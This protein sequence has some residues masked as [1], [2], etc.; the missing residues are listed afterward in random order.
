MEEARKRPLDGPYYREHSAKFENIT[1]PVL[2]AANWGGTGMHPRGNYEGYL[3]A[4]ST[5][6]W[7]SVHGDTHFGPFYRASGVNMQKQFLDHFLKGEDNGWDKQPQVLIDIRRPGE[8]FTT[9]AEHEWPLARTEWTKFY[10]DPTDMS[11]RKAPT[12]VASVTYDPMG[13]GLF[14]FL[15][16]SEK[17]VEITGPI[18]ARLWV[19]SETADADLFLVLRLYDPD[20]KEILFVGSNDPR[21]PITFGW[22]RA[23]HRKLDPQK[24]LPH[25]PYH[26]H[27]EVW[28][29]TPGEPVELL[30][31]L[32][33]TCIVIPPGYRLAL[34]IRGKDYDNGLGDAKLAD[35]PY[36]MTGVGPFHHNDPSDRP[37][38]IFSGKVT[39]HF[40][41]GKEP[42]IE[43]PIIPQQP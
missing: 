43:L 38:A 7:L 16:T 40:D 19:S 3:G 12:Q 2:S 27:D 41:T 17:E 29:L 11:L 15:P 33:P 37:P 36:P 20:G 6:K 18:V 4:S 23:S 24:S 31:E 25:R 13:N 10:L 42:W 28:P 32:W 14:Y 35:A 9:R 30:I 21:M 22:L 1:V 34:N 8:H 5:Q 39:L 26:S